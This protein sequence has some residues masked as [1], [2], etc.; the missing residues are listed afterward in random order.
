[1]T[2]ARRFLRRLL[3]GARGGGA[4]TAGGARP[5]DPEALTADRLEAAKQRLKQEIPPPEEEG[6][7]GDAEGPRDAGHLEG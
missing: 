3:A 5:R 4:K 6:N 2:T 7:A 1:M